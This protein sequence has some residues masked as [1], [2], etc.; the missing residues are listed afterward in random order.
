MGASDTIEA[1]AACP[2][3]GDRYYLRCETGFFDPAYDEQRTLRPGETH[4]LARMAAHSEWSRIRD[5]VGDRF[6]VLVDEDDMVRCDCGCPCAPLLHFLRGPRTIT[7]ERVELIDARGDVA[8]RVDFARLG[9]RAL[10]DVLAARFADKG[11]GRWTALAGPTRCEACSD[12]RER[13]HL[14]LLAHPH[15]RVGQLFDSAW[16]GR[17]I[18]IGDRVE[19]IATLTGDE[20]IIAGDPG[21]WGC[22][23]GAGPARYVARFERA[24]DALVLVDLTLRAAL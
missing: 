7:L 13:M 24:G 1:D 21:S 16:Q 9:G 22:R 19:T 3:C 17:A 14:T 10:R 5:A 15:A 12:A 6:T 20:I 23:C 2:Q 8:A 4:P 18:M 11:L